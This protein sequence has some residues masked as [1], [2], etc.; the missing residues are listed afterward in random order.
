MTRVVDA[1]ASVCAK[2]GPRIVFGLM[3][4]A[5]L[6]FLALLQTRH[7]TQVI[8]V[9]H[10]A[11]A[12]AM[13]D[14]YARISG[15]VGVASVTNGP[16]LTQTSTSLLTAVRHGTSLVLITGDAP[17][18]ANAGANSK[19]VQHLDQKRWVEAS[20]AQYRRIEEAA[21]AWE[22]AT[23][24]FA[25]AIAREKVIV[26]DVPLDLTGQDC[27]TPPA[28]RERQVKSP[29]LEPAEDEVKR[30]AS[31]LRDAATPILL[32]GRGAVRSGAAP[33]IELLAAEADAKLATTLLAKGVFD[34]HPRDIGLAGGFAH[35]H[36][37][38]AFAAAD[39]VVAIGANINAF[40]SQD[41]RLFQNAKLV[42]I[43]S[44][45]LWTPADGRPC[46][47]TVVGDARLTV[48]ALHLTTASKD[49]PRAPA[50]DAA[51]IS[52]G[53]PEDYRSFDLRQHRWERRNDAL[54]VR[55]ALIAIDEVLPDQ[56]IIVVGCG[57]FFTSAAPLLSGR[58][59]RRFV[60]SYDFGAIGQSLPMSIGAA[61]ADPQ[62]PVCLIDGDGSV[63]MSLHELD[64]IRRYQP[65]LAVIV[66]DDG[67]LGAE[68]HK[69][70]VKGY[71]SRLGA[72]DSPRFVELARASN[73]Q[74][75]RA[76]SVKDLRHGLRA[77][78]GQG[79]PGLLDVKI[80][81]AVTSRH[82]RR[83]Y[84]GLRSGE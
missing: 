66:L 32:A 70:A 51:S 37:E 27:G 50:D 83:S 49:G 48:E 12:V 71:D 28:T 63:A 39:L 46:D 4:D 52:A 8:D 76:T 73:I 13:A 77:I 68:Y 40:T 23:A 55:E 60:F 84:F 72:I 69:L 62:T 31:M 47:L 79:T 81:P 53:Q 35:A 41:R 54:D 42:G 1:V 43:N 29:L 74:A 5:N 45:P 82:Y 7:G 56:C 30:A 11:A 64:T 58:R 36:A 20:G 44:D 15:H 80:N 9:R 10:E 19:N 17:L 25:E 33:A 61:F 78:L 26:L 21:T 2:I 18:S 57:H 16:G 6:E 24:A 14:A 22:A 59:T 3:G 67:A 38:Q 65:N 34:G 75:H